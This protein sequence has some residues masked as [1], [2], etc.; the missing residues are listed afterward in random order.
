MALFT[1]EEN[2][3]T[4]KKRV[5]YVIFIL[6]IL[7]LILLSFIGSLLVRLTKHRG[8][9]LENAVFDPTVLGVIK[10]QKQF[11]RYAHK[12]NIRMFYKESLIPLGII[13]GGFLVYIIFM[14]VTENWSYNP[15]SL[16]E[17]FGSL[18]FTFDFSEVIQFNVNGTVGMLLSWPN[19]PHTPVFKIE[20][21]CGYVSCIAWLVGGLWYLWA[22]HG[23]MSRFIR[24]LQLRSTIYEKSLEGF[25]LYKQQ[26]ANAQAKEAEEKAAQSK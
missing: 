1:F 4:N 23:F 5:L 22:V 11:T 10:D 25:N 20:N 2:Q 12:K 3:S 21:W 17:G 13:L 15:W 14:A 19:V 7:V 24:L 8:K 6:L 9:E 18:F 16:E 26:L